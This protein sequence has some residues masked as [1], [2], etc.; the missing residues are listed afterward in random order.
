MGFSSLDDSSSSD[1]DDDTAGEEAD[2]EGENATAVT[3]FLIKRLPKQL[4]KLRNDKYGAVLPRSTRIARSDAP[5]SAHATA[6]MPVAT[7]KSS[8]L[9]HRRS[10]LS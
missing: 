5:R 4:S 10:L 7:A 2:E 3:R 9:S 8:D 1:D 6:Q